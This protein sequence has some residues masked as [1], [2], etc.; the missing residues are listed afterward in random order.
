M[1][2]IKNTPQGLKNDSGIHKCCS[3]PVEMPR[4]FMLGLLEYIL[5]MIVKKNSDFWFFAFSIGPTEGSENLHTP[6]KGGVTI[7]QFQFFCLLW[8]GLDLLHIL[9]SRKKK[10]KFSIYHPPLIKEKESESSPAV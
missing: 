6:C 2:S 4:W 8:H 3:N 1:Y 5:T 10:W 7:D 9:R